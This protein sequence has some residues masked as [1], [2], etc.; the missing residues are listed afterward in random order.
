[1]EKPVAFI[2]GASG[3]I[4]KAIARRLAEE[5]YS[6]VLH[7][8]T[9]EKEVLQLKEE[10]IS[11]WNTEVSLFKADFSNSNETV[12]SLEDL[13]IIADVV[14]LNSGSSTIDLFTDVSEQKLQRELNIGVATPFLITQQLLPPLI[15]KKQGKVIVISS[16][17]GI[18]GAACEVLYSTIKGALNAFVK[19]LAKEVAPSNIQV[20]GV[21][22][23]AID[24]SMLGHYS[25]SDISEL[26][27]DIPADRLG[28]PAEVAATV[29]FLA[30]N[31][32]NYINGQI[33]SVNGAWYC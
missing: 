24:T 20:N 4:G 16:I 14:V 8:H 3:G 18:T 7:Y 15:Q 12:K 27:T 13:N 21:A 2:T 17:W 9:N 22:P 1:M 10:L 26:I 19:A 30:S 31:E 23:G 5:N 33:I 29:A 28:T 32:S 6:L 11:S 25:Q